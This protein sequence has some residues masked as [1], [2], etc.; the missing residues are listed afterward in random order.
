MALVKTRFSL[1]ELLLFT[2]AVAVFCVVLTNENKWL[3]A[4][5]VTAALGFELRALIISIFARGERRA[6]AL[7]YIVGTLF[8][9]PSAYAAAF[10][11]PYLLTIELQTLLK[12]TVGSPP[13]DEHFAVVMVVFWVVLTGASAGYLGRWWYRY[14]QANRSAEAPAT[15]E[16]PS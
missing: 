10:T 11:L 3:R 7:G 12:N 15:T 16:L 9:V 4:V 14:V 1:V 8:C 2:A 13:S 6:F 5:Y